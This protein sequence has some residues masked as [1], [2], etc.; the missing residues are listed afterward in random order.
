[1]CVMSEAAFK[2]ITPNKELNQTGVILRG[3][4]GSRLHCVGEFTAQT[5]YK[6]REYSFRVYVIRGGGVSNLL[7]RAVIEQMGLVK[8]VHTVTAESEFGLMKTQPVKIVLRE[9]AQPYVVHTAHGVPIP[10]M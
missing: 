2:T 1:M 6:N 9:D 5:E 4:D 8:R 10:L 7:S 3:P